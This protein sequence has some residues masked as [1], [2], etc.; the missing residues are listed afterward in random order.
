MLIF[1][2]CYEEYLETLMRMELRRF[3][4]DQNFLI[5]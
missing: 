3:K 1:K 5:L 4:S 2:I